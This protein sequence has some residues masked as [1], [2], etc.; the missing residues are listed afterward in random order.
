MHED[1]EGEGMSSGEEEEEDAKEYESHLPS[2]KKIKLKQLKELH[3][4]VKNYG[5]HAPFTLS[6]LESTAGNGYLLPGECTR[7]VQSVLTRGQYL[8][9]KSEFQDRA[10]ALARQYRKHPR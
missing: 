7:M 8:T 6:I 1:T 10:D 9:W 3:S 5:F 2:Y 4:V